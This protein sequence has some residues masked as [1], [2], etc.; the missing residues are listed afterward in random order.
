MGCHALFQ[1]ILTTQGWNPHLLPLLHWQECFLPLVPL[2]KLLL[3]RDWPRQPRISSISGSLTHVCNRPF[4]PHEVTF[5][6]FQGLGLG[7]LG[8]LF[9][10]SQVPLLRPEENQT[11]E[12]TIKGFNSG[13][14]TLWSPSFPYSIILLSWNNCKFLNLGG[15]KFTHME[16]DPWAPE[17][18]GSNW[19]LPELRMTGPLQ[20]SLWPKSFA[21]SCEAG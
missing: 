14:F 9:S 6:I 17:P 18:L 7:P 4:F 2:G 19:P 11:Y 1:G 3:I 13:S 10:L 12:R 16:I 8:D 21:S 15:Y 5:P 20:S